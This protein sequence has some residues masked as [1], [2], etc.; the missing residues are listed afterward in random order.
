MWQAAA[1]SRCFHA[2]ARSYLT[3]AFVF[4][5]VFLT[6]Q[7]SQS[8][9]CEDTPRIS[10][11]VMAASSLLH[12]LGKIDDDELCHIGVKLRLISGSSS[13]L[14]RQIEQGFKADIFISADPRWMDQLERQHLIASHSRTA[15]SGNSLVKIS[16]VAQDEIRT[17]ATGDPAHVPLGIYAKEALSHMGEWDALATKIVPAMNAR[18]AVA[19]LKSGA[20]DMAILYNSDA[21][22]L[23]P[24]TMHKTAIAPSTHSPIQYEAAILSASPHTKSARAFLDLLR[25]PSVQTLFRD[26][27]FMTIKSVDP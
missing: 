24:A 22:H 18:A 7:M 11:N 2:M 26:Y 17:W 12:V 1:Q 16:H 13:T 3:F 14:S 21:A 25:S 9:N 20:V 8:Q 27:G 10:M 15:I 23:L 4:L 5:A 6:P 19:L